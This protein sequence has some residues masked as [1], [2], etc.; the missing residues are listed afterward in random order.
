[1]DEIQHTMAIMRGDTP[2]M[3]QDTELTRPYDIYQVV[4]VSRHSFI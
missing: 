3:I 1:M 2:A 4:I